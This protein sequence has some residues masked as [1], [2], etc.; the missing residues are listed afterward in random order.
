MQTVQK[1]RAINK[2]RCKAQDRIYFW[3]VKNRLNY[4]SGAKNF[5]GLIGWQ[6][7]NWRGRIIGGLLQR[8]NTCIPEAIRKGAKRLVLSGVFK[9]RSFSLGA[10]RRGFGSARN[11][12]VLDRAGVLVR[13]EAPAFVSARSAGVRFHA[14]RRRSARREAPAFGTARSA[15]VWLGAKR[16]R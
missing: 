8:W 14:K 5:F 7:E 2:Y 11:A 12:G 10:K 16:L 6:S 13:R 15:G 1:Y 4:R 3:S 9:R